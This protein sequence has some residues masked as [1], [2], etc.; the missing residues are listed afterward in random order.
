EMLR[1][2]D[3]F[4]V[5]ADFDAYLAAQK[6]A[7]ETWNDVERWTTM[8][9]LNTARMGRFSSDRSIRE[10]NRDIWHVDPIDITLD[11]E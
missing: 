6:R 7:G 9:I 4:F 8:S 11:P 3:R 2:H 5:C 1:A 10:Y